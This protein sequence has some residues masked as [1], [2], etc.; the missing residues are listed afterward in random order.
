[1]GNSIET[2]NQFIKHVSEDNSMYMNKMTVL[3][4]LFLAAILPA[5]SP[6]ADEWDHTVYFDTSDKGEDKSMTTWGTGVIGG[7]SVIQSALDNMGADQI[8]L[9][10]MPFPLKYPLTEEG[11]LPPE[12]K[13]SI[14]GWLA[15]AKMA[16][17]KPVAIGPDTELGIADEY[18]TAPGHMDAKQ[19]ARLFD[20]TVE[21][22]DLP[23]AWVLPF[24]EP[25]Y[26]WGQGTPDDLA[27]IMSKLK[28]SKVFKKKGIKLAGPAVLNIDWGLVWFDAIRS[29]VDIATMHTLSGSFESYV[30]FIE[31]VIK[32][33]KVA[34]NPEVHNLVEVIV[35]A[36][37]G[38]DGG[39]WWLWCNEVRGAFVKACQGKRLAYLEDPERWSAAAVY[40]APDGKV[41]AFAGSNERTGQKTTYRFICEDRPV[42]FNG[43]G[44][45]KEF[46]LTVEQN[47]E[48]MINITWDQNE[49]QN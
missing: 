24:N 19:W 34:F 1:M 28:R 42:Y 25:D 32:K 46:I 9:V 41:Q 3:S 35:G 6:A 31:T 40:R 48:K 22:I 12:A 14:D 37:Y 18:K 47:E 44:P 8:D 49:P 26:G 10:I 4:A 17:N 15:L 30:N 16:G 2:T 11:E 13:A 23:V 38:M 43:E 7:P 20:A 21:Y 5:I 39:I 27:D 33:N 45:Q 29:K 36:E